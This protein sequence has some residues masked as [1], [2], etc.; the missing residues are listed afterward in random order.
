VEPI[1]VEEAD[2]LPHEL[3]DYLVKVKIGNREVFLNGEDSKD[4]SVFINHSWGSANVEIDEEGFLH[5]T[6]NIHDASVD[7]PVELLLNY[8]YHYWLDKLLNLGEQGNLTSKQKAWLEIVIPDNILL[9]T[10]EERAAYED[11]HL[12]KMTPPGLFVSRSLTNP[13]FSVDLN[14]NQQSL[15]TFSTCSEEEGMNNNSTSATRNRHCYPTFRRVTINITSF[16]PLHDPTKGRFSKVLKLLTKLLQNHDIVYIQ[17]THLTTQQQ[18]DILKT[19]FAGCHLIGSVSDA[20]PAQA[21]VLI[22]IKNSVTK[23]YDINNT[24]SSGTLHGKGRV[25]SVKFTPKAEYKNNL[26]SFRETCI[27]LKSGSGK[28]EGEVSS[29]EERR[30]VVQELCSLPNDTHISFM[31][32]DI[33]QHNN[34]VLE[35]YLAANHME[36]VEQE[37]NT[38]YRMDKIKNKEADKGNFVSSSRIDRWYCNISAAQTANVTPLTRVLSSTTGTVG[39]YCG[40]RLEDLSYIPSAGSPQAVHI[41]DHVP[42]GLYLPPPGEGGNA[43]NPTTIPAWVVRHPLF[44]ASIMEQ[45]DGNYEEELSFSKLSELVSLIS[46]TAAKINKDISIH[47][48]Q[49]RQETWKLALKT[50]STLHKTEAPEKTREAAKGDPIVLDLVSDFLNDGDLVTS[51][52]RLRSY[53]DGHI[54]DALLDSPT[55]HKNLSQMERLSKAFPKQRERVTSLRDDIR[56]D[57]DNPTEMAQI[58]KN[59]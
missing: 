54:N 8:G 18:I 52:T 11:W 28:G 31:G 46:K 48:P 12:R 9:L 47:K 41:T 16:G 25:V 29:Q 45:W 50:L 24:Y 22:I 36:E 51:S 33:N 49:E 17:E 21:G 34:N 27:Y 15:P 59:Y 13:T 4:Y 44:K 6:H 37:I 58:T 55:E 38:F 56:E 14:S 32:G 7:S 3:Q 1:T 19:Y 42:V 35:P 53:L 5:T 57:T 23:H 26:F 39:N 30:L 43:N 10:S 40:G 2:Q 20:T